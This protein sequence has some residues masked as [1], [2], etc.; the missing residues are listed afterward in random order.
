MPNAPGRASGAARSAARS[1]RWG[2]AARAAALSAT[3]GGSNAAAPVE[4]V[5][6]ICCSQPPGSKAA[7]CR[8]A[9]RHST[10]Q[11]CQA[12]HSNHHDPSSLGCRSPSSDGLPASLPPHLV[13]PSAPPEVSSRPGELHW[14]VH[15]TSLALLHHAP[16]SFS[17][18]LMLQPASSEGR[19]AHA[20]GAKTP[21]PSS[22]CGFPLLI[23]CTALHAHFMLSVP[24]LHQPSACLF[25][26]GPTAVHASTL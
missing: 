24:F 10:S 17:W 14:C 8:S 22:P 18:Q 23:N 20:A 6:D 26:F 15:S 25:C 13:R 21:S 5:S 16:G 2:C 9:D 7:Y 4:L 1:A 3:F 12:L 19:C 11:V